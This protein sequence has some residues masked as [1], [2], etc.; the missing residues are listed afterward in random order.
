MK[1]LANLFL[2]IRKVNSKIF[3]LILKSKFKKV[4]KNFKFDPFGSYSFN[5]IEIGNDVFIGS[6]AV[7]NASDSGIKI[8]NKVMFGPNVTI[9]GGD[10]NTSKIGEYMFD[11]KEKLPENDLPIIIEDDVWVG[12]GVIIL[13][14]VTIGKGCIIAAGAVVNRNIPPYSIAAGVPAKVIKKRF[15]ES[16]IQIHESKLILK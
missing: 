16:E 13:K 6:G 15:S 4:G 8:G 1:M 11:V 2:F 14:G 3:Q 12:T 5:T 7:L 9:M 10:H